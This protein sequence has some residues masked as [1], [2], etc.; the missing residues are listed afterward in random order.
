MDNAGNA[1]KSVIDSECTVSYIPSYWRFDL[2]IICTR[3][4]VKSFSDVITF[5]RKQKKSVENKIN[6]F[7]LL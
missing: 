7:S 2:D 4:V 5:Y 3:I 1:P 6:V